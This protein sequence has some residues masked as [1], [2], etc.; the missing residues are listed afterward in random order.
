M[1][2]A[3][4]TA[5]LLVTSAQRESIEEAIWL[6]RTLEEIGVPFSG[7]VVNRVHHDIL[8]GRE[9]DELDTTLAEELGPQLARAVA[10]NFHDYHV[11]A[12]RDER[13]I[14]RLEGELDGDP[15]LLVPQLD[16]DVHDL[17]GL[18]RVH[19]YL[20][21]SDPERAQLIAAVIA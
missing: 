7:V 11:L 15:L 3:P 10:L 6:R 13:N 9:P 2:T 4:T 17:D 21:A 12:R 1:L 16:D 20:F 19:R 8:A 18:A 5:M 14:A